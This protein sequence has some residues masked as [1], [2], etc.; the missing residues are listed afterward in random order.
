MRKKEQ[1][2]LEGKKVR[3][4]FLKKSQKEKE[5]KM[6]EIKNKIEK[7]IENIKNAKQKK[8]ILSVL[9]NFLI[10]HVLVIVFQRISHCCNDL[11]HIH[12]A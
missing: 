2:K 11:D 1:R 3:N 8:T 4:K 7:N 9:A 6:L 5:G 10:V 12:T